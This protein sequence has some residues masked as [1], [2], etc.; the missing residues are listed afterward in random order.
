VIGCARPVSPPVEG[1]MQ[2]IGDDV[3]VSGCN[4]SVLSHVRRQMRCDGSS[5]TGQFVNCTTSLARQFQHYVVITLL[6]RAN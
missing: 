2:L 4:A 3:I 1:W 5:W 6:K